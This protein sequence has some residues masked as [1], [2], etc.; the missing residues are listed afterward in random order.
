MKVA[1]RSITS[2]EIVVARAAH[3]SF[4]WEHEYPAESF[5]HTTNLHRSFQ[6]PLRELATSCTRATTRAIRVQDALSRR[7]TFYQPI[8]GQLRSSVVLVSDSKQIT[9]K[10]HHFAPSAT[11]NI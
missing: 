9:F 1:E 5:D 4:G 10:I 8:L 3:V 2:E 6:I 11:V 7:K